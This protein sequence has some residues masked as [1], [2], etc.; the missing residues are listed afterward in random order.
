MKKSKILLLTLC[1][2]LLVTATILGTL[3]FLTSRDT[4]ENTF[5]VGKVEIT[6]DETAVTPDGKAKPGADR[7][8]ENDYHLIPGMTY[9][10]DPTVTV[11]KGSEQTYVRMLVTVSCMKELD[12]LF[13]PTGADLLTI[14]NGYDANTWLYQGVDRDEN[15]NTVTYEFRYKSTVTPT[16]TE[17][18][19][20]EALFDSITV[21]GAFDGDDMATIA[22]MKITVVGHAIQA[23]GFADADEAWVAFDGQIGG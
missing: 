2:A 17:D 5:T 8:K 22:N 20:L 21:P 11:V 1:A 3:A 13:A 9:T 23:A 6:L 7:V 18:T 4:V 15:A 16:A 10:K 19:E 12:A 14:F